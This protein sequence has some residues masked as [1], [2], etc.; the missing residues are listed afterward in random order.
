GR[1][2]QWGA[3]VA[4]SGADGSELWRHEIADESYATPCLIDVDG[5]GDLVVV[6]GRRVGP[7]S[8]LVAM[9]GK[10][11][12]RIWGLH[13]ANPTGDIPALHFNT[14]VPC[15]DV[16]GDGLG[17]LLA[18]QGGG[19]D[20]A[21]E[22]GRLHITKSDTG[23]IL[24]TV[25]T[26]DGLE[27]FF[28]PSIERLPGEPP[29]WRVLMATGGETLPGNVF[30]LDFPELIERWRFS[31]GPKK[32]FVG[33]GILHDFDG[34]GRDAVVSAF[35]SVMS[36]IDGE[37]GELVWQLRHK[38][39]ETYVTPTPG[40]FGGGESLDLVSL[41][42]EGRWPSYRT[43][44]VLQ[45]VD[46]ETGAVIDERDRGV[47]ASSSPVVFDMNGDGW[48]EVLL[49]SNLSFGMNKKEVLCQ[50]DLFDGGPGKALLA[51][52]QFMGYSAATP[53]IGHLDDD[54]V[55]D[56]IFVHLNNV[57]RLALG[58]VPAEAISWNQYRGPDQDGTVPPR[59]W[60]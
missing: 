55:M 52:R 20:A 38:R 15:P 22:A 24:R 1:E 28:V 23:A 33:S 31:S 7:R 36:R 21:R 17:D 4:L 6:S 46:G 60:R 30:S 2:F 48:D 39:C 26:P 12:E 9:D 8:G 16:D 49:V 35:N 53:W 51:T 11:G 10:T 58:D 34:E 56:V 59:S 41:F 47:Q 27:T 44:N 14:C 45:W 54:G 19:D 50:L 57:Y 32:G 25:P 37:T 42:S 5:D 43:R 13:G 40:H 3:I 18:L 29:R